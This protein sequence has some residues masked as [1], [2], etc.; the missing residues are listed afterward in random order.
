MKRFLLPALLLVFSLLLAPQAV[1]ALDKLTTVAVIDIDKV[2]LAYYEQSAGVRDYN[3]ARAT[4]QEELK[5]LS[6]ELLAIQERKLSAQK[7]LDNA[8]ALKADQELLEKAKFIRDFRA[9]KDKELL[10]MREA[11]AS[12]DS[13]KQELDQAIEYYAISQGF[14]IVVKAGEES[15]VYWWSTEVDITS[16][17]ID[18]L[19]KSLK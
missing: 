19:K 6:Q 12:S 5:V 2:Y 17:V 3:K 11:L 4:V 14:T 7:A 1:L 16:K 10:A 15:N 18:F 9:V 8:A 13:F